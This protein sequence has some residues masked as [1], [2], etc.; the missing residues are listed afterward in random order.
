M[1]NRMK[2]ICFSILLFIIITFTSI[3]IVNGKYQDN[4]LENFQ[5]SAISEINQLFL[6]IVFNG[7]GYYIAP[8]GS[9]MNPGTFSLPWRTIGKAAR[10]IVAGDTVYIR[11]GIYKESV[12][13]EASGTASR[14]IR[15]LAY[16]GENPIIDG[17]NT[18]P[19]YGGSLLRLYGDYIYA[20]G[21]EV[22]NSY[23]IG[24]GV[25]GN[26]DLVDDMYVHHNLGPGIIIGDGHHSTVQNSFVWRSGLSNEYGQG[27]YQT[28]LS[29]ARGG[30]S[31]AMI[32]H[33]T[34]WETW[35]EGIST[36]EA[37]HTVIEDNIIHDSLSVNIYISDST[38][39]LCQRNFVYTDPASY[40]YDYGSHVGIALGD[41]LYTPASAN[42]NVINN[43]SYGNHRNFFWWQGDQGGGMNNVLIA[44]NTFVNGIGSS[45]GGNANVIIDS[46]DHVNVRFMNNLV[47]QDG[48]LPVID[49][50][51][52]PEVVYSHNLWSKNP[53]ADAQGPGDVIGDP[54]LVKGGT[55]YFPDWFRLTN[56]SPAISHAIVL[57]EVLVDFYG[58]LRDSN[59][60]LGA[61]EY[62]P[63]P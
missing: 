48:V 21:I 1:E 49:T 51:D 54:L 63:P 24:I 31:Y 9:D 30:V 39:V 40:V 2:K 15:I 53:D 59:P 35:G 7:G 57:P 22:R 34:V 62:F 47:Q 6:P 28:G 36:F 5:F 10:T 27:S 19:E 32:R 29:A 4:L 23:Y 8:Y 41:E 3:K 58:Y 38:N 55:P 26:Y 18:I 16:Q 25:Y 37:D 17:S 60:D 12:R 20:S 46:G 45:S 42:I 33:N 14:P 52:H 61:I 50:I 11:D 43:I 44:N 13:I 56:L